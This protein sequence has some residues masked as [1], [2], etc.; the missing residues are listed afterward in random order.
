M[1]AC[2][3]PRA[4]CRVESWRSN[5]ASW[6]VRWWQSDPETRQVAGPYGCRQ[7]VVK[8]AVR[9]DGPR[10]KDACTGTT[11]VVSRYPME[12]R[13]DAGAE[14]SVKSWPSNDEVISRNSVARVSGAREMV[15]Q[16]P[17]FQ[18]LGPDFLAP[19]SGLRPKHFVLCG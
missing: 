15:R 13:S 17:L 16:K 3:R 1:D 7:S 8:R 14:N 2:V 19:A 4:C 11:A 12:F 10:G 9:R 6:A 18:K 5:I